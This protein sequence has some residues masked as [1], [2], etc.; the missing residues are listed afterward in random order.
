APA[1]LVLQARV[2]EVVHVVQALDPLHDRRLGGA[3][4]LG[5]VPVAGGA[6]LLLGRRLQIADRRLVIVELR[7]V[8]VLF[9][10]LAVA[11]A[12]ALAARVA[13]ARAEVREPDLEPADFLLLADRRAA[14]V[15]EL[16][17]R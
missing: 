4:H 9:P 7:D 2:A 1:L 5:L 14:L 17:R 15:Q 6:L 11:V 16:P 12:H 10:A 8:V 13:A 3:L